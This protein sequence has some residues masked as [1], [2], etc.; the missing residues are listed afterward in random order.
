[1]KKLVLVSSLLFFFVLTPITVS[2]IDLG[3]NLLK[4][5]AR[6]AGYDAAGTT[7]TTF[8]QKI[9]V[10]VQTAMAFLGIIFTALLVYA[11]FTWMLARGDEEKAKKA[12]GIIRMAIIGLIIILA[13]YSI[14]YFVLK[15]LL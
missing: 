11:G 7:E 2:A 10:V 4:S 12:Q 13:S 8:A 1:M 15:A 9:G 6:E 14:S 5:A 3:D